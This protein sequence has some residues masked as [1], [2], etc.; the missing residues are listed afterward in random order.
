MHAMS[1]PPPRSN[2]E[3]Q[4]TVTLMKARPPKMSRQRPNQTPFVSFRYDPTCSI[5][6]AMQLDIFPP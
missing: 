3:T 6:G 1:A 2:V 5:F 4:P